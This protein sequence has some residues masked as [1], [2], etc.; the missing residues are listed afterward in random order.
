[1]GFGGVEE[2]WVLSRGKGSRFFARSWYRVSSYLVGYISLSMD[3][4]EGSF[5]FRFVL[6]FSILRF[7]L[8]LLVSS[9][10]LPVSSLSVFSSGSAL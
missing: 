10:F 3:L 5:G 9:F 7:H 4:V 1:M 2:D 8:S 6:R